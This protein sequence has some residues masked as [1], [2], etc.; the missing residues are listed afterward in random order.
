MVELVDAILDLR[1][2]VFSQPPG[3]RGLQLLNSTAEVR[4]Q[5]RQKIGNGGFAELI[6]AHELSVSHKRLVAFCGPS[7]RII[8]IPQSP[9]EYV[10]QHSA[11]IEQI[12]QIA[13]HADSLSAAAGLAGIQGGAF[14]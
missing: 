7:K 11:M 4:G 1:G 3:Q 10:Y 2:A 14:A 6:P 8:L 13:L 5:R 12:T 9:S